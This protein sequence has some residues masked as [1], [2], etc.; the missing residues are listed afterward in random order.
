MIPRASW[1]RK[2]TKLHP[3][4]CWRDKRACHHA[5]P[6][7]A[8][9]SASGSAHKTRVD[10]A[11]PAIDHAALPSI[12]CPV[13][14]SRLAAQYV[15]AN[16]ATSTASPEIPCTGRGSLK[17]DPSSALSGLFFDAMPLPFRFCPSTA[18]FGG[19]GCRVFRTAIPLSRTTIPLSRTTISLSRT[20]ISL[21]R[22]TISLSRTT[23]SLSRTAFVTVSARL[24][25][26][27]SVRVGSRHVSPPCQTRARGGVAWTSDT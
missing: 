3:G 13:R 18:R 5:S 21:S 7:Q 23:I 27:A 2:P 19:A 15:A 4:A 25:E 12:T 26:T 6:R 24:N 14:R 10:Q 1:P 16:L 17:S 8:N 11:H 22:T 20:T 9:L